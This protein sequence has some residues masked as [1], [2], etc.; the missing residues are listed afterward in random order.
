MFRV[1]F[2]S[3]LLAVSSAGLYPTP[4]IQTPL[5]DGLGLHQA[6]SLVHGNETQEIRE[7]TAQTDSNA[8]GGR[9][10]RV[11]AAQF[12]NE[13]T[14]LEICHSTE[15]S[16]T[17][18]DESSFHGEGGRLTA[19]VSTTVSSLLL[20]FS[21]V[22][23]RI[24]ACGHAVCGLLFLFLLAT[25]S[26]MRLCRK[27]SNCMGSG[28]QN[29]NCMGSGSQNTNCNHYGIMKRLSK[30]KLYNECEGR[31]R[32][33]RSR[34]R[35]GIWNAAK[36]KE[37]RRNHSNSCRRRGRR[38]GK[39]RSEDQQKKKKSKTPAP[40]PA[41][42]TASPVQTPQARVA[43][44][45][46]PVETP[47]TPAPIATNPAPAAPTA[48]PVETP[49]APTPVQ[50]NP[51]P[52]P[53]RVSGKH[54]AKPWD[55]C[56]VF[57]FTMY[58]M[59]SP[60]PTSSSES[61]TT[62]STSSW[63][64]PKSSPEAESS[65]TSRFSSSSSAFR[66]RRRGLH[67]WLFFVIFVFA[68]I[69][70]QGA[71]AVTSFTPTVA[72]VGA[73]VTTATVAA[74]GRQA[75]RQRVDTS[76]TTG[77]VNESA[78]NDSFSSL[79]DKELRKR[80]WARMKEENVPKL[81]QDTLIPDIR[82]VSSPAGKALIRDFYIEC[83]NDGTDTPIITILRDEETSQLVEK[84][85]NLESQAKHEFTAEERTL[86]QLEALK[87]YKRAVD[88]RAFCY[89]N[90]S[91]ADRQDD[92]PSNDEDTAITHVT[93]RD[94]AFLRR[95][96]DGESKYSGRPVTKSQDVQLRGEKEKKSHLIKT[97][98]FKIAKFGGKD[99]A[100]AFYVE[101]LLTAMLRMK[102]RQGQFHCLNRNY[103]FCIN[104]SSRKEWH[105]AGITL[106][107]CAA[108]M[109]SGEIGLNKAWDPEIELE[110]FIHDA[111]AYTVEPRN[112][113]EDR[114]H[115]FKF[116]TFISKAQEI[117]DEKVDESKKVK[118]YTF[119]YYD[120]FEG[121]WRSVHWQRYGDM[122]GHTHYGYS[123]PTSIR[124]WQLV[125]L[126]QVKIYPDRET[127]NE[128]AIRHIRK[129]YRSQLGSSANNT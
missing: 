3:I 75:K 15:T 85:T 99:Q 108:A 39:N 79:S 88:G 89:A 9:C 10:S 82:L 11:Y 43:S 16:F 73:T 27:S 90:K 97:K 7:T 63:L 5:Q 66:S 71:D 92:A 61:S 51:T 55:W 47:P 62:S 118:K 95:N 77:D 38:T 119:F 37:Y 2:I 64:P 74:A 129:I 25:C 100:A 18:H 113:G 78:Q 12:K 96:E 56:R 93:S 86:Y 45:P 116:M 120:D 54:T 124:R 30:G 14:T 105:F 6:G 76:A 20:K 28:S 84:L 103:F 98:Y 106:F 29:A 48:S 69:C 41:A 60:S 57:E 1:A 35:C 32:R 19:L 109:E 94:N 24:A 42:P 53:A 112:S 44:T 22:V 8:N 104:D 125:L 70:L 36:G 91:C 50:T 23:I 102:D 87:I 52:T 80:V 81:I 111:K 117:V 128:K 110:C 31:S 13:T 59:I 67:S 114:S 21:S 126:H 123:P 127:Y 58:W 49:P 65:T 115:N 68:C 122:I 26:R 17:S 34:T 40:T 83:L 4:A 107:F 46:A 33:K 121:G 101:L 72:A